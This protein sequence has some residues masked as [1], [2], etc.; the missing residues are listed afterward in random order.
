MNAVFKHLQ[1]IRCIQAKLLLW[2]YQRRSTL[3]C[4]D[5]TED[6]RAW[7]AKR[8]T[9][10]Q[11]SAVLWQNR[12]ASGKHR[13]RR[14]DCHSGFTALANSLYLCKSPSAQREARASISTWKTQFQGLVWIFFCSLSFA[15]TSL[16]IPMWFNYCISFSSDEETRSLTGNMAWDSNISAWFRK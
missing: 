9:Q 13:H 7:G 1:G 16:H 10:L 5:E 2:C 15:E 6:R 11:T 4:L 14:F 12:S 3:G 8:N